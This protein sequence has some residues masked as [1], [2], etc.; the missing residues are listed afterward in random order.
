MQRERAGKLFKEI[1]TK[2]IEARQDPG[3]AQMIF[4]TKHIQKNQPNLDA[5]LYV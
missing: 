4:L 5:F 1:F 2:A 3:K